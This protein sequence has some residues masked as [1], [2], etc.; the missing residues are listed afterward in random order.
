MRTEGLTEPILRT[1][2]Q[3][4]IGTSPTAILRDVLA[5]EIPRSVRAYLLAEVAHW[6]AEDLQ[7][8]PRFAQIRLDEAG[9]YHVQK[10]MLQT[11]AT[12]Y[13]LTRDELAA[14]L[15]VAVQFT[16]NYL[17]RPQWTLEHFAFGEED[18]VPTRTILARLDYLAEY[19]YFPRLLEGILRRRELREVSREDFK[20]L[21]GQIDDQI[22]KQHN[23]R[24]LAL[25]TKPIFDF[26]LLKDAA[27]EDA[28]PLRPILLFFEDKK[29]KIMEE[30]VE[31]ICGLRGTDTITLNGLIGLIEELYF[32]QSPE[33]QTNQGTEQSLPPGIARPGQEPRA[34][35]AGMSPAPG[36]TDEPVFD[37][38][39]PQPD[40]PQRDKHP[41]V[42]S[43][44]TAAGQI[45]Q[46]AAPADSPT[47]T[48]RSMP[49]LANL[50]T[51]I[52]GKQRQR[53]VKKIFKKDQAYYTGIINT[54][55]AM[56][57]WEDA[58]SYL[59][60]IYEIHD[61]DPFSRNVV[62]F[63]DAVQKRYFPSEETDA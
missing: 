49:D 3:R 60:H 34:A 35:N 18:P 59:Q 7:K 12:T 32:G 57:T 30:Y 46:E 33:P 62:E 31:S 19:A 51:L 17:T 16:N 43:E 41:R 55:N 56:P 5:G 14:A 23:P 21:L 37:A 26:L 52:T 22:V 38:S 42:S 39:K 45:L 25:L 1:L 10:T 47:A 48:P 53:F 29:M 61:I 40:E 13:A 36:P 58:S 6:L 28:I 44:G 9:L 20:H 50:E 63:T 8:I 24:E 15:R 54:L 27:L 4:T 11:L 2:L